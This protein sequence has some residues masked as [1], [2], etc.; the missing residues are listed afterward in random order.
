MSDAQF[1]A[2]LAGSNEIEGHEEVVAD[3]VLDSKDL[4]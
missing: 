1:F 4:R 3:F 2:D